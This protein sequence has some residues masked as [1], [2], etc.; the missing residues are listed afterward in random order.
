M[1]LSALDPFPISRTSFNIPPDSSI[2]SLATVSSDSW[3]SW[4]SSSIIRGGSWISH[5]DFWRR[6]TVQP[7]LRISFW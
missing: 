6:L 3:V 5:L 2:P 1:K 4:V 7:L